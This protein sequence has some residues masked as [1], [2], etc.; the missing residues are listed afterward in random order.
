MASLLAI[1]QQERDELRA[2]ESGIIVRL[3]AESRRPTEAEAARLAAIDARF[4]GTDGQPGLTA[5]ITTEERRRSREQAAPSIRQVEE[6]FEAAAEAASGIVALPAPFTSSIAF[7]EQLMAVAR[8]KTAGGGVD[9]R[10]IQI[11][12]GVR[13]AAEGLN[14]RIDSEGGFLVQHDVSSELLRDAYETG[15]VVSRT[16]QRPVTGNGL[17][18]RAVD[19]T[20]RADGSRMGGLQ[21]FWTGEAD[22]MTATKPKFRIIDLDLDKLTGVYYATDELLEDADALQAEVSGWFAEEFG[23]KFDDAVLRGTGAG[24]PLGLL[25]SGA[26]ISVAAEGGQS[27]DTVVTKNVENMFAR[28]R[29][30]SLA[31]AAWFINQEVWP[32]IFRLEDTEGHRIYLPGGRLNE[33]PF[34][35]LLG[36]PIYPIEQA[37]AIGDV[38]D[39]GLYDLNRYLWIKKGGVQAAT[40]IHVEFLSGQTAFRFVVRANGQPIPAAA[41]TPYKGSSTLSPFVTLAAR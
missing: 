32:Q 19:E 7:G 31:R 4:E 40:S 30:G 20:S 10:L 9:P 35:T 11:Q 36:L 23:F 39:I 41:L 24:M 2:E 18:I 25:N 8:A 22:D 17:K 12:T 33:A 5:Q 28:M 38:G 27:A 26:L 1:L 21:A 34:G 16:R 15:Q 13:A 3:E 6:T 14:E 29:P 37:S